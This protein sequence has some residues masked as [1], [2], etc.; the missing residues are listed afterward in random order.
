MSISFTLDHIHAKVK[1]NK[2]MRYFAVFNRIALAAGFLPAGYVKIIGE[3]FANGL[4]ENHPMGSYLVALHHTGYYYTFIGI[5]QILAAVFF[6]ITRTATLGALIYFP[7]IL[8]ISILSIAVRF[9]GSLLTA[10]LMVMANLYLLCWDYDKLKYILPFHRPGKPVTI[11][12]DKFADR[13]PLA[14]FAGVGAV[15]ILVIITSL[16]AWEIYPRN[17]LKDCVSQCDD[18][19]NPQACI[20]FCEC[21]HNQSQPLDKC[22]E[23]YN[24]V[25]ENYVNKP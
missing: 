3:R 22:L 13:F 24:R 21:I 10:P 9:E 14:F 12:Q 20:H 11:P 25:I 6:L 16:N 7:I 4:P 23:E 15:F 2:W 8:N 19:E 1:R 5:L 17:S 18:L